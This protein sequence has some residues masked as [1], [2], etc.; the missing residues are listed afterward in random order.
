M[1]LSLSRHG[2]E[3]DGV[4]IFTPEEVYPS[5]VR[6]GVVEKRGNPGHAAVRR[7][8]NNIIDTRAVSAIYDNIAGM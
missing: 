4:Q 6:S 7:Y 3:T 1:A 8:F 5:G 2:D